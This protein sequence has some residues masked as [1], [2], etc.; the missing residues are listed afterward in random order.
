MRSMGTG[1]T[2][3]AQSLITQIS[4]C[5]CAS[6]ASYLALKPAIAQ[7]AKDLAIFLPILLVHQLALLLLVLVLPSLAVLSTLPLVLRHS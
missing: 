3:L 7:H 1:L 5:S 4:Q 6:S 2:P